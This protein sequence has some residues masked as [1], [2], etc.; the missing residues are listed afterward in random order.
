MAI[1]TEWSLARCL[2]LVSASVLANAF[3]FGGT[4]TLGWTD[5][6]SYEGSQN[7]VSRVT[8]TVARESLI[9][10]ATLG[11][12]TAARGG[13]AVAQAAYKGILV[14][15]AATGGYQI[16]TGAQQISEGNYE[17]GALN[18]VAGGLRVGGSIVSAG[19]I[20]PQSASSTYGTTPE[21]RP[22]TKHYATD[23]GPP[24]NIPGSVVDNTVNTA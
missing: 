20:A 2:I 19:A 5:S 21:G 24:R 4:D 18:V 8:A 12:R 10:A 6:A 15:E 3:T 17:A 23:T 11:I 7:T 9:T 22:L 13:S 14:T 1:V 16:G